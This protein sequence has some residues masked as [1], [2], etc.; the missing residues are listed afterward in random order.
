MKTA[1]RGRSKDKNG[2]RV[3]VI[4]YICRLLFVESL[5]KALWQSCVSGSCSDSL[6]KGWC[7]GC[8]TKAGQG[9][10]RSPG[11]VDSELSIDI[12]RVLNW[13]FRDPGCF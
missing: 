5:A 6:G 13:G 10:G 7:W 1:L 3:S 4:P 2:P 9:S 12:H 11:T 8:A